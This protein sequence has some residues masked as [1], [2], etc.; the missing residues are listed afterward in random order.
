VNKRELQRI[1]VPEAYLP[2]VT[3]RRRRKRPAAHHAGM[4]SVREA[5]YRGHRIVIRTSYQIE[6]DGRPVSGH[7]EVSDAGRVHYHPLPNLSFGSAVDMVKQ[8]IDAFPDEYATPAQ[9]TGGPSSQVDGHGHVHA[10]AHEGV[11]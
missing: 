8:V 6:V 1:V 4:G 10:H 7:L 5:E 3:A 11:H 9:V 2:N